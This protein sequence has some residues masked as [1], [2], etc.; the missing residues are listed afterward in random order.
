MDE[1]V[2]LTLTEWLSCAESRLCSLLICFIYNLQLES[3]HLIRGPNCYLVVFTI[4]LISNVLFFHLYCENNS[5]ILLL[6][7]EP[8]NFDMFTSYLKKINCKKDGLEFLNI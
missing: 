1:R 3:F 5:K 6:L 4:A 7:N 8:I 2:R